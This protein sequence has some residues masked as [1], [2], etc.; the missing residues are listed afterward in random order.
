M[1]YSPTTLALPTPA[2]PDKT[3]RRL[4]VEIEFSGVP[5]NHAAR[6]V[7]DVTDGTLTEGSAQVWQVDTQPL[8]RCDVYLDTRFRDDVRRFG[9]DTAID[10]ARHVV[11]VE[12]VTSP[13]DPAHLPVLQRV[14]EAL[15]KVGA[16][17]SRQGMLLGFGVHLNME[18]ADNSPQTLWRTLTAFALLEAYLRD[19]SGIDMSR[20][21]LPFVEPYPDAL[22]DDLAAAAP[23]DLRTLIETY[24]AHAPTRNHGLDMLPIFAHLAPQLIDG[25]L[26][27]VTE[28]KPRPAFH[29]RMLDC[30]IDEVAWSIYQ[31]WQAWLIVEHVAQMPTVLDRLRRARQDRE[32]RP[33]L[34]RDRWA[35]IVQSIIAD[36]PL[37]TR[38][39]EVTT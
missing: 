33:V 4:G 26:T 36:S 29:F 8:G 3:P 27:D 24:L 12:L 21:V 18:I 17:G 15:R 1:S 14:V 32:A 6:I 22:V 30:R 2:R 11:P 20:Q 5:E 34:A 13:F 25:R 38:T 9:G 31:P 16:Q 7:S 23:P 19:A 10:L 35:Q 28:T 37:C 39:V